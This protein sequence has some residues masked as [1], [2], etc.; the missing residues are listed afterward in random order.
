MSLIVND[1]CVE[2]RFTPASQ[3][4]DW[5]I[6]QAIALLENPGP[7]NWRIFYYDGISHERLKQWDVAEKLFRKALELNPTQ[8]QVLN[9]LGYSFVDRGEN[10]EEALGMIQRAVAAQPRV[11][12]TNVNLML[13]IEAQTVVVHYVAQADGKRTRMCEI[14]RFESGRQVHGEALHGVPAEEG[15]P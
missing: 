4:D 2:P 13:G 15:T 3:S 1:S 5:I 7:G 11:D 12:V 14:M 8:P 6:R 10:L 9:Y